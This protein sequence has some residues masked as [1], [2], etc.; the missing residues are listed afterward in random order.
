MKQ[1]NLLLFLVFF[2]FSQFGHAQL[3][4]KYDKATF[5]VIPLV[6]QIKD[7]LARDTAYSWAELP[8][9]SFQLFD[10]EQ[11]YVKTNIDISEKF[12]YNKTIL[13]SDHKLFP[14][15]SDTTEIEN[16]F[17]KR[18]L[19]D[20]YDRQ[21]YKNYDLPS[22]KKLPKETTQ[23]DN[24]GAWLQ[25]K[26]ES[27]SLPGEMMFA[28]TNEGVLIERSN[29]NIDIID[30]RKNANSSSFNYY[31]KLLEKN[32]IVVQ[33]TIEAE[34]FIV[35]PEII[36]AEKK[37]YEIAQKNKSF[38]VKLKEFIDKQKKEQK[39]REQLKIEKKEGIYTNP[40]L[41]D[42]NSYDPYRL[43]LEKTSLVKSYVFKILLTPEI[44]GD[45]TA[46]PPSVPKSA[47]L[48][49]VYSY[50]STPGTLL[51]SNRIKALDSK[52][53][54]E[55]VGK[56]SSFKDKI[57]NISTKTEEPSE[58]YVKG[59]NEALKQM[60][61]GE[62]KCASQ[63]LTQLSSYK[64]AENKT[65]DSLKKICEKEIKLSP[66][67]NPV[68][69]KNASKIQQKKPS[70]FAYQQACP[71]FAVIEQTKASATIQGSFDALVNHLERNLKDFQL[72][73]SIETIKKNK[74]E[75]NMEI[76]QGIYQG[77][78][79]KI[80]ERVEKKGVRYD[81]RIGTVKIIKPSNQLMQGD[82]ILN[83][84]LM[85]QVDGKKVEKGALLIEDDVKGMVAYAGY[86]YRYKDESLII[87]FDF[88]I[89]KLTLLPG[90]KVGLNYVYN[91]SKVYSSSFNFYNPSFV[92]L[93]LANEMYFS[94]I[95]DIVP[96]AEVGY[97]GDLKNEVPVKRS[98]LL[99]AGVGLPFNLYNRKTR[100]K[101][102]LMPE[103]SFSTQRWSPQIG[104]VTKFEF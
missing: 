35:K 62:F 95:F 64:N 98:V 75:S 3:N 86:G 88:S 33:N 90:F 25:S 52:N 81:S 10:V 41:V 84:T 65:L 74:I 100:N 13:K 71:D 69:F 61:L 70:D 63:I 8:Y 42:S 22:Y 39:K 56:V 104:L 45:L 43:K 50:Y 29:K 14:L 20:G 77:Q 51:K 47:K 48:E 73:S 37:A 87:G 76:S 9:S 44:M 32:Y 103:F 60:K 46:Y 49:F 85:A 101:V 91:T 30:I 11:N 23:I 102:K 34:K 40:Y 78:Q 59:K 97:G 6:Y 99:T 12:F 7:T 26:L 82:S 55:N 94:R 2:S 53:R 38:L 18:L 36:E 4:K 83:R 80:V 54:L 21:K 5:T 57:K 31:K 93:R 19:K 89:R 72:L 1:K 27:S 79:F 28:W 15:K 92:N 58:D 66:E 17:G 24:Y 67:V 96:F 16:L 68:S